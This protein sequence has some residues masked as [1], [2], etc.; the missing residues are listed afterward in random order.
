MYKVNYNGRLRTVSTKLGYT[1]S[2]GCFGWGTNYPILAPASGGLSCLGL[3]GMGGLV[4][5]QF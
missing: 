3:Q 1:I 5:L 4:H 2:K